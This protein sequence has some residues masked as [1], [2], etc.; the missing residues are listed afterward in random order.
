MKLIVE[1]KKKKDLTRLPGMFINRDAGNVEANVAAFNHAA[2]NDVAGEGGQAMGENLNESASIYDWV[3]QIEVNGPD[4][5]GAPYP[6]RHRFKIN[7]Q[8]IPYNMRLKWFDIDRSDDFIELSWV[9]QEQFDSM[10]FEDFKK[11]VIRAIHDLADYNGQEKPFELIIKAE[12]RDGA[13]YGHGE[14]SVMIDVLNN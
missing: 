8:D 4:Y 6:P 9:T 7:E 12:C 10:D 14:A 11:E 5:K 1:G 2:G 13:Q 3:D